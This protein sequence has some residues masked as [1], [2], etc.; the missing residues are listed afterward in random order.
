MRLNLEQTLASLE[1]SKL[2]NQTK[3]SFLWIPAEALSP[4]LLPCLPA[5]LPQPQ[6]PT[7]T[8]SKKK[9]LRLVNHRDMLAFARKKWKSSLRIYVIILLYVIS[10]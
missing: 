1:L 10:Q 2:P 7:A 3:C 6:P 9:K 8:G 5:T 4:S